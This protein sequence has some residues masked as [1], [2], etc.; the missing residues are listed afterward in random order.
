MKKDKLN[1]IFESRECFF[2]YVKKCNGDYRLVSP[3]LYLYKKIIEK[4]RKYNELDKL[5]DDDEFL[6]L[7]YITL[8][9]WNMN[10]RGAKLTSFEEF[11]KSVLNTR[12]P[13]KKLYPYKLNLLPQ[14]NLDTVVSRIEEIFYALK[15]MK[16]KSKIVGISK[17]LHFLLPNLIMPIDRK[18]TL[19][20][21]YGNNKYS[22]DIFREFKTFREVFTEFYQISKKL[23]LSEKDID[24]FNWNTSIPKLI[25]NALIGSTNSK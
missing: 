16:S 1:L 10:Q 12:S 15:V 9:A 14:N 11:R 23:K 19:N 8:D 4:H 20:T 24:N 25:D 22:Q 7:I 5:L 13:L 17:A 3:S 21:F 6:E 2:D 18:Y